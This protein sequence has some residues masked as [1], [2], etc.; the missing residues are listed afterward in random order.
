MPKGNGQAGSQHMTGWI[1]LAFGI[2]ACII[3]IVFLSTN[4]DLRATASFIAGVAALAVAG[5]MLMRKPG[6]S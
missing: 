6:T 3:G 1:L 4:H 5:F 2:V